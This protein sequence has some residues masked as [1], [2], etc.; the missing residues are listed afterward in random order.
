MISAIILAAGLSRRM[1]LG[2]KLLLE[3]NNVPII[4][5]TLERIKASKVEDITI[6]LG[7]DSKL[8]LNSIKDEKIKISLNRNYQYGIAASI[9]KGIEKVDDTSDGVIICL[10]DMPLIKTST[11]N[12]IIS[13]FYN[14]KKKKNIIPYFKNK[15][16]NPVLFSR[17]YFESLMSIKG[18]EGAKQL[19]K[20]KQ[21]DF[22]SVSTS[23]KGILEDIDNESQYLSFIKNEENN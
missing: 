2:N 16:G 17:N 18:D 3:K 4:K 8:I 23:D 9:K 11:Y 15:K 20:K 22:I 13:A 19:I 12:K 1:T 7:K 14:N 21:K 10:G 6:V 5:T